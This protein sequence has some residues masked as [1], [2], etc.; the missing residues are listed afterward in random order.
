MSSQQEQVSLENLQSCKEATQYYLQALNVN[1]QIAEYNSA[2]TAAAGA[3][4][5]VWQQRKRAHEDKV[6]RW[7]NKTGEYEK[8]KMAGEVVNGDAACKLSK[9][10]NNCP[11]GQSHVEIITD[12]DCSWLNPRRVRRC[13]IN[14]DEYQR[15]RPGSFT[16]PIPEAGKGEYSFAQPITNTGNIQCCA[17]IIKVTGNADDVVQTCSQRL[18]QAIE[19]KQKQTA[20]NTNENTNENTNQLD[21]SF[22]ERVDKRTLTIVGAALSFILLL[23]CIVSIIMIV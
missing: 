7:Q 1:S 6:T 2:Q 21:P 10:P 17:N 11:P 14:D 19:Q 18:D 23:L 9:E 22:I 3:A 4:Y 15:D 16:E 12:G 8:H 5:Q 20:P 13:R